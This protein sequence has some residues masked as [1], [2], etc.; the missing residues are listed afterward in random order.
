MDSQ[1]K[2]IYTLPGNQEKTDL[3]KKK[4]EEALL[5]GGEARIASQHKKGK[6]T[7]RERLHLLLDEGSF[8][9]IDKFV[10]HRAKD[11]GL[12][13][14]HYLGDGVVT[15]YGEING[16]LVYVFS[17]DFTVFG[18]S[19]SETHAEKICKIMDMAMKNG[20]P[21]IGLNDSGGAR[22]QEGV[23]SLGGYADIFY[24]NTLASGVIPQ[25]SAIMGP[26]AGGAVYSPAITD[27]ILMVEIT[28]YMFVTG[29][30]VVKTVTQEQ[31]TAEELGGARTHSTKSGVTHFACPNELECIKHIRNLLSY[32]P[33][34][35]E[36]TAPDYHYE[37]KED[38]I[39]DVL[40]DIIPE[41]PTH[42]YDMRDVIKGLSDEDSFLE[43]HKDFADNMV[44]GFARIAGRSIGVVGNQPQSLAGVLDND[45]SVKAARFV[46][47]CDCFNIP[48]L[49]LVDVPGF[50]PG[51]DQEWNGI[52]SNG[53]KLLY[54]FSEATV[55]RITVITRK[56]YGGAYD[57][58]NSKHIGADL[59]FA[60][61]T[62]EIA[63]MGAKG[64]AE[65]IFKR[66]IAESDDPEAKLQEKVD[67]YTAKFANPYRAAHRGFIDEVIMPSETRDKLIRGFK[68][69]ENKVDKLP[70][71]K[72]GNIPL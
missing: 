59:N 50:L 56:A 52:I 35:C 47:F 31:V 28:S 66:E 63:V 70:R 24:R 57:V 53:A 34:N 38:E 3:L 11:F 68:M 6:L 4:N 29:P 48:L 19:L 33:Q 45:A 23:S 7:A 25:I 60:W 9:E 67:D 58:M 42:P 20:A 46:R 2:G 49:V 44:V 18:G 39:R 27:F 62:A 17:Q 37:I 16:R 14:E 51:T 15:G 32:I 64:A 55:P 72:H 8:Q 10:T 40:D 21:V 65:I 69:L 26:C 1:T 30:N 54:A 36:E 22:I 12:D 13:K 71:K 43:V 5:G 61:P 41:N